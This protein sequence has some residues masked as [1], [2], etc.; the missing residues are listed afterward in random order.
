MTASQAAL[1]HHFM[2]VELSP[3]ATEIAEHARQLLAAGGYNGF[4]YADLS[5]R[6]RVGKASIHH[7][8]PSKVDLVLTV[9][10]RGRRCPS[11]DNGR[12]L[13]NNYPG[14]VSKNGNAYEETETVGQVVKPIVG[15][16]NQALTFLA[17]VQYMRFVP[18]SDKRSCFSL[19]AA[20]FTLASRSFATQIMC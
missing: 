12:S 20:N 2:T 4:S 8:F 6:V 1:N 10:M 13:R 3:R 19:G 18:C 16:G 9:V 7:H 17:C 5:E 15:A 14:A 11:P